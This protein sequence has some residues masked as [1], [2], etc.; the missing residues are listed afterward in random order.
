MEILNQTVKFGRLISVTRGPSAGSD[1]ETL[2]STSGVRPCGNRGACRWMSMVRPLFGIFLESTSSRLQNFQN[3]VRGFFDH[4]LVL[5]LRS[6][7]LRIKS[8]TT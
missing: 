4:R 6:R 3:R 7:G 2:T 8:R 1:E 5:Y